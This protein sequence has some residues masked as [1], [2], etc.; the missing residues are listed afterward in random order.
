M[1]DQ[2]DRKNTDDLS[3]DDWLRGLAG[4]SEDHSGHDIDEGTAL[5][6][7]ILKHA[8]REYGVDDVVVDRLRARVI[9]P[10]PRLPWRQLAVAAT[11][12]LG[13]GIAFNILRYP[14]FGSNGA[15]FDSEIRMSRDGVDNAPQI[16]GVN[17]GSK[18]TSS[19]QTSQIYTLQIP[20]SPQSY[21]AEL[22]GRL[23]LQ[24]AVV[25]WQE[26]EN[27]SAVMSITLPSHVGPELANAVESIGL[28]P[29]ANS[30]HEVI[31]S[32]IKKPN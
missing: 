19:Q 3:I 5:R 4:K 15:P 10:K 2:N 30:R 26:G 31:I 21:A 22:S 23:L 7:Q 20:G 29:T 32:Q 27:G 14:P 11:L 24:G 25:H 1:S 18:T 16:S 17:P 8:E 13:V 6:N 12:V 28:T 9:R